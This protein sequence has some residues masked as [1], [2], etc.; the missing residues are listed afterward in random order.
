MFPFANITWYNQ[1]SYLK[2]KVDNSVLLFSFWCNIGSE[3]CSV[4]IL[5]I[6]VPLRLVTLQCV[7][8]V[9]VCVR[10]ISCYTRSTGW[11]PNSHALPY[12]SFVLTLSSTAQYTW[13]ALFKQSKLY[14]SNVILYVIFNV[15]SLYYN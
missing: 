7:S 5:Q 9:C 6:W 3:D 11:L 8:G 2:R 1:K 12:T 15:F 13:H 14:P 10:D 4:L